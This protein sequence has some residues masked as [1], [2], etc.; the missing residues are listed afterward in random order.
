MSRP[1]VGITE[2]GDGG[3]DLSWAKRIHEVTAMIVVTKQLTPGCKSVLA[4]Y[5]EKSILHHTIT[6]YGQTILEPNVPHFEDSIATVTEFCASDNFPL[7]HVVIR[8]DPII[9][10]ERGISR[11]KSVLLSAASS[12]FNRF[13]VSVIDMYPHVAK[14]FRNA[15]IALP[16][17]G[18]QAP[19]ESVKMVDDMLDAVH[20]EYP[21]III[22][23]CAE[24]ALKNVRHCGCVSEYDLNILGIDFDESDAVGYQRKD[25]MCFSGKKELLNHRQPCAHNCLYCYWK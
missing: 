9:P 17:D 13:R 12:R 23:A 5:A 24:R 10:T 14:R 1:T 4:K 7:E 3:L 16:F 6:G 22:E 25:C 15:G 8:V 20:H 11:A 2:A 21:G 18:F 19:A